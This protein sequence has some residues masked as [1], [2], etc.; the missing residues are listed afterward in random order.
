M[1]FRKQTRDQIASSTNVC[2]TVYDDHVKQVVINVL[3]FYAICIMHAC[4]YVCRILYA[5]IVYVCMF[6]KACIHA[7]AF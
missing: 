6:F 7:V 4:I 3:L 5:D 1:Y 2:I